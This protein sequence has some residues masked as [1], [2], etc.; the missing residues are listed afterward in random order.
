M[1]FIRSYLDGLD[2]A[3]RVQLDL[4][5]GLS[6]RL[7]RVEAEL[8]RLQHEEVL[9]ERRHQVELLAQVTLRLEKNCA[10]CMIV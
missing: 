6:L 3:L 10:K 4:P 8:V 1:N 7:A 5:L 9:L 2:P